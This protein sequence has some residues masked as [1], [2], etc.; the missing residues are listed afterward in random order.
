MKIRYNVREGDKGWL[1]DETGRVYKHAAGAMQAIRR[2]E[3]KLVAGQGSRVATIVWH[4][5]TRMGRVLAEVLSRT[6]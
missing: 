4:P 2:R 1:C 6:D 5:N 3:K